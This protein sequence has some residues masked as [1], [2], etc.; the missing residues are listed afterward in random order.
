MKIIDVCDNYAGGGCL[1]QYY[2]K[3]EITNYKIICMGLNLAIGDIK[4]NHVLFLRTLYNDNSYNYNESIN[5]LLNNLSNSKIRI[6]SSRGSGD[7]YLLLLYLCD[8]LKDKCPNLTVIY[9]TDYDK[10]VLSINSLHYTEIE[11]I[12]N[13]EKQLTLD[14]IN[15]YSNEWG[16]L[17]EVN[18]DLRF[19]ENG[20]MKNKNYSD[21]DE[22]IL[23][24]L[25]D[26]EPCTLGNLVGNLI[27]SFAIN[28]AGAAIYQYLIDRLISLNKIKVIE[29][30]ERHFTDIISNN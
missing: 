17:V 9:T 10:K 3:N 2:V 28:D 29:N 19:L 11:S 6:W 27:T 14:D 24:R 4:N 22:L 5:E 8:L 30:G 20:I 23:N 16:K 15:E 1:K 12:L 7:D 26:L 13:Y 18:S 21:Y 25:S